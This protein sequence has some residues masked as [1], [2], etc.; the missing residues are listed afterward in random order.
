MANFV[1]IDLG[2][3]FSAISALDDLGRPKIISTDSGNITPSVVYFDEEESK[4]FV[5]AA[6][7]N[8]TDDGE[9]GQDRLLMDIKRHMGDDM[10]FSIDRQQYTPTQLSSFILKKLVDEASKQIGPINSAVITVPANFSEKARKATMDAGKLIGL[11]VQHII[12]EPTAAALAYANSHSV[13]GNILVYDLGGGTF[14][15]TLAKI[16][17]KDSVEIIASHGDRQ[18]GGKDFDHKL[19]AYLEKQYKAVKGGELGSRS[20]HLIKAEQCKKTLTAKNSGKVMLKGSNGKIQH[21]VRREEFE[22]IISEYIAKTEM[23]IDAVLDEAGYSP[24]DIHQILLVGGSSRI[25]L[26][27]KS[28]VRIFNKEPIEAVNPDEVVALGAAIYA[29]MRSDKQ[30][31]NA[32]QSA[33]IKKIKLTEVCGEY[34]G[35]IILHT[36]QHTGEEE[37]FVNIMLE[38]NTPLPCSH[39]RTFYTMADDQTVVRCTVTSSLDPETD[40]QFVQNLWE[41]HLQELPSGRPAGQEI[42]VTFSFNTSQRIECKYRDVATG[43]EVETE[44]YP[45]DAEY[46]EKQ[47]AGVKD[48]QIE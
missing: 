30:H 47:Q 16:T 39:T 40:P 15:V 19:L 41:G 6:A 21:A 31:L 14:D 38:K 27:R 17:G 23:L 24:Q 34:Y 7:L 5:G 33:A 12:N 35:T 45:G 3:T 13:S 32:A 37:Y 1:G 4:A 8:I 46:L 26:V 43:R 9:E 18:L 2:T 29:G 20:S 42:E 25:P 48:F 11:D 44:V 36:D 28:L 22:E 10:I